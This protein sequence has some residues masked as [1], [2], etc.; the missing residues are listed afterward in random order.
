MNVLDDLQQ[1][2]AQAGASAAQGALQ[3]VQLQLPGV[4]EQASQQVQAQLPA[5]TQQAYQAA[6]PAVRD[7]GREGGAAAR[8]G[9]AGVDKTVL[10]GGAA[11]AAA[12]LGGVVY[13]ATRAGTARERAVEGLQAL[14]EPRGDG[15]Y[16]AVRQLG[17][18]DASL[19]A[20]QAYLDNLFRRSRDTSGRP[21]HL[22]PPMPD[23]Q[24]K[25]GL[26]KV[27]KVLGLVP[28]PHLDE[29]AYPTGLTVSQSK[30]PGGGIYASREAS[31][32]DSYKAAQVR[33]AERRKELAG[34]VAAHEEAHAHRRAHADLRRPHALRAQAPLPPARGARPRARTR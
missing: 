17:E 16:D 9:V 28:D 2:V 32:Y 20:R 14:S 1:Q 33:D 7:L 31:A 34:L 21:V 10:I 29:R 5:L 24:R 15:S 12:I 30:K 25:F 22:I 18:S 3:Q 8:E 6:A 23:W 11:L 26:R 27:Q 13:A 19:A 4:V